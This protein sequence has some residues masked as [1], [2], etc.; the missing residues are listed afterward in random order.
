MTVR[1]DTVNQLTAI[2]RQRAALDLR[3]S[4]ETFQEIADALG[5][6]H[7]SGAKF[8]VDSALMKTIKEPADQ[9]RDMEVARMDVM[10]KSLWPGVLKGNARTVEVAIKVLERRAKLLGLD[11]PIKINIEQIVNEAAERYGL[12][13]DEKVELQRS[14][15][16]YLASQKAAV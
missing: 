4:G 3:I 15:V 13:E 14:I 9:L 10:L 11:A 7:A 12:T 5:Y 1:K 6:K 16:E 2:Q 8:A